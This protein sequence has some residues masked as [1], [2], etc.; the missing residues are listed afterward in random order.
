MVDRIVHSAT[1][2]LRKIVEAAGIA[3][4][5]GLGHMLKVL[6]N[7]KKALASNASNPSGLEIN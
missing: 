4:S 2:Q 5:H 3:E 6:K 7:L 1:D